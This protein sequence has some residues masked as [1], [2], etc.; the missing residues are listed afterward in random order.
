MYRTSAAAL[1]F[2]VAGLAAAAP[3][4]VEVSGG[5]LR[6]VTSA[7]ADQI[8]GRYWMSDGRVLRLRQHGLKI[9]ADLSGEQPVEVRAQSSQQLMSVD[10]RMSLR[11]SGDDLVSHV[12]L[13]I[14]PR[15]AALKGRAVAQTT[16]T[17]T[18][19]R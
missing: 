12:T 16:L 17:G 14:D 2:A 13:V 11:F 6:T 3:Q 5:S 9:V 7:E 19:A 4:T 1:S 10:G 18:P 15:S 8:K